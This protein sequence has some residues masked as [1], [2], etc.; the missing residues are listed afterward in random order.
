GAQLPYLMVICRIAHYVKMM[1]REHIGSWHR[2]VDIERELN[3]WLK[4]YVAD[5]DNPAPG[6]RGRRPLRKAQASVREIPGKDGWFLIDLSVTPHIRY[7]GGQF[8]L[9]A[10]GKLDRK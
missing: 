7:M 8:T 2:P 3:N 1:Q 6:V 9:S 4:Q 5:M 10:T